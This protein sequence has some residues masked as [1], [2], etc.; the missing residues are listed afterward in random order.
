MNRVARR[1][2][3]TDTLAAFVAA[4]HPLRGARICEN[5]DLLLLTDEPAGALPSNDDGEWVD[6]AGQTDLSSAKRA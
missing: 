3:I 2:L 6:L 5:G 4:G 1:H